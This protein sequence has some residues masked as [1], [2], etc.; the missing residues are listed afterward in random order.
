MSEKYNVNLIDSIDND[1]IHKGTTL[2][3]ICEKVRKMMGKEVAILFGAGAFL[4]A[5]MIVILI[6][7]PSNTALLWIGGAFALFGLGCFI[8][9]LSIRKKSQNTNSILQDINQFCERTNSPQATLQEIN[10]QLRHAAV[11]EKAYFCNDYIIVVVVFTLKIYRIADVVSADMF[12]VNPAAGTNRK[13]EY[14]LRM[15]VRDVEKPVKVEMEY[16]TIHDA[17]TYMTKKYPNIQIAGQNRVMDG[18]TSQQTG[19]I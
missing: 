8:Y 9:A 15:R 3:A 18:A 2:E 12:R 5:I 4:L 6:V 19:A 7:S 17:L 16:M 11:F 1:S 10:N 13:T 14:Y